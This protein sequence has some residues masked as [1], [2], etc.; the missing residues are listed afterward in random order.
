MWERLRD[1]KWGEKLRSELWSC[2]RC[3]SVT[4]E[5]LEEAPWLRVKVGWMPSVLIGPALNMELKQQ[6]QQFDCLCLCCG[7][8]SVELVF[9]SA[10]RTCL[11]L[12]DRLPQHGKTP[13]A[14]QNRLRAQL[15]SAGCRG[16][17]NSALFKCEDTFSETAAACVYA[18]MPV[19][20]YKQQSECPP[21]WTAAICSPACHYWLW[22]SSDTCKLFPAYI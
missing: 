10:P 16:Y 20:A 15:R 17:N 1:D 6:Q 3:E 14:V 21:R 19:A 12:F 8:F 7:H 5:P 11:R 22:G 4:L 9:K 2:C 13:S 18:S